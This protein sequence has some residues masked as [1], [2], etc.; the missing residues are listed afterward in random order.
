MFSEHK[1]IS[2]FDRPKKLAGCHIILRELEHYA[3]A[4][5]VLCL[6]YYNWPQQGRNSFIRNSY[7][8][9]VSWEWGR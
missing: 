2:A 4:N 1:E 9:Y 6:T 8:M 7:T 3:V 5:F